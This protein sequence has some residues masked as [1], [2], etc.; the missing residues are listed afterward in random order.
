MEGAIGEYNG[1]ILRQSFDVTN[2]VTNAG[3]AATNVF[4]AVLLG[5][6]AV[7]VDVLMALQARTFAGVC[8]GGEPGV[9]V[10]HCL[11][12]RGDQPRA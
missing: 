2:G 1:V 8:A 3:A 4:R 9:Q 5:G 7:E 12:Q 6:Q 11:P 10:G